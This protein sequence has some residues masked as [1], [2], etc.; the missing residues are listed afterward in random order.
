MTNDQM[1]SNYYRAGMTQRG[2]NPKMPDFVPKRII[3]QRT[4]MSDVPFDSLK[5]VPGDYDVDVNKWG[6]VSV[7]I[8]EKYLGLR[9]DEFEVLEWQENRLKCDAEN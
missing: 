9:I 4:V 6:A 8:G 1:S 3:L 2:E 5:A 7:K